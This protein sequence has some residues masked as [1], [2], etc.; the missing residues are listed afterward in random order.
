MIDNKQ[1]M[2]RL[3]SEGIHAHAQDI[4]P[5]IANGGIAVVVYKPHDLAREAARAVGWDGESATFKLSNAAR[6]R[7]IASLLRRD[8][9]VTCR[10]LRGNRAGR[11]FMISGAGTLLI[12]FVP[13]VGYS[14]EPGSTDSERM[15]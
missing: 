8:D 9:A 7:L 5:I 3:L 15:S 14:L 11:I 13:G 1:L 4:A 6:Q 2:D 12:N 10:W